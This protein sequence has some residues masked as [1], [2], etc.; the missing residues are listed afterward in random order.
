MQMLNG[1]L[2]VPRLVL[3]VAL[4]LI[5][6]FGFKA[7]RGSQDS[8]ACLPNLVSSQNMNLADFE[9]FSKLKIPEKI[10][11]FH[12]LTISKKEKP[13]DMYV[14]AS[15]G[16]KKVE[17][18]KFIDDFRFIKANSYNE[19]KTEGN[20]SYIELIKRSMTLD[21]CPP[22]WWV[23]NDSLPDR[24]ASLISSTNQTPGFNWNLWTEKASDGYENVY[25][26]SQAFRRNP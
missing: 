8:Q 14:F 3:L 7:L 11:N 26:Y 24:L 10:S 22:T 1:K 12:S 16:T 19:I 25:L 6:Y 2:G 13:K 18:V 15:F 21:T 23:K 5:S 9:M 17:V 4:F 20:K